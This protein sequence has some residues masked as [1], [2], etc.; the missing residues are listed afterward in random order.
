MAASPKAASKIAKSR[1]TTIEATT[2]PKK[3][4]KM[5]SNTIESKTSVQR[6]KV[7]KVH[8]RSSKTESKKEEMKVDDPED[9]IEEWRKYFTRD[10][11]VLAYSQII[12][13]IDP[14]DTEIKEESDSNPSEDNLTPE[15]MSNFLFSIPKVI[16][17]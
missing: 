5:K 11:L 10:E 15:E 16:F 1:Q 3:E 12:A 7:L 17:F 4:S 2:S 14:N 9:A 6:D 8:K 13:G